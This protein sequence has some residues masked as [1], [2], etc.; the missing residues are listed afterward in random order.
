MGVGILRQA[1]ACSGAAMNESKAM[2]ITAKMMTDITPL[3]MS[4][5]V[6]IAMF[7]VTAIQLAQEHPLISRW[8]KDRLSKII[9]RF[10]RPIVALYPDTKELIKD[11]S[12]QQKD[13]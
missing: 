5:E 11:R 1:Q 9:D 6:R 4:M 12:H 8:M 10:G 13:L 7:V 3:A 2:E